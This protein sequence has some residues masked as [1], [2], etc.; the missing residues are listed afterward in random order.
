L[1][2]QKPAFAGFCHLA[3]NLE[4]MNMKYKTRLLSAASVLLFSASASATLTADH[5][6]EVGLAAAMD[7]RHSEALVRFRFAAT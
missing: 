7:H 1:N 4:P 3:A 5:E 6:Y 2:F